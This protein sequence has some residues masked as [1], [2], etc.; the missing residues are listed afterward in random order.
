[1]NYFAIFKIYYKDKETP[2]VN[3]GFENKDI[4]LTKIYL[5]IILLKKQGNVKRDFII[6]INKADYNKNVYCLGKESFSIKK[7]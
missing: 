1:M 3:I 7:D 4:K 6:N 5:F 2:L